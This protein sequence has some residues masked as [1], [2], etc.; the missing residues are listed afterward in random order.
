MNDSIKFFLTMCLI[1]FLPHLLIWV[2]IPR[3]RKVF[4]I[5]YGLWQAHFIYVGA[6]QLAAGAFG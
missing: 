2:C 3:Y 1:T 5:L 6:E 4:F